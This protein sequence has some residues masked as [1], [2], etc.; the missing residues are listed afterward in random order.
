MKIAVIGGTGLLGSNLIKLF[1]NYDV[2]AFS[3][4][5]SV[6]IEENVNNL[7]DFSNI[8]I[9]LDTYFNSWCPDLIINTVALVDL[10]KCEDDL[11]LANFSN[12]EISI[13]L[14][15]LAKKNN[16]Y[17]IHVSTDHYYNDGKYRHNENENVSLLNNYAKTKY[18]AEEAVLDI[19]KKSLIVRTNIIGFRKNG[20]E[21]FFEW[22][23][24]NMSKE[25]NINLYENFFTSP[26][27]VNLLGGILLKCYK[28]GLVG[29]YNISSCES[30]SKYDFGMK[31]SKKFSF[32][33]KKIKKTVLIQNESSI[34]RA[35]TLGLNTSKIERDLDLKM[36]KIEEVIDSLY[37][38]YKKGD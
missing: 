18:K 23:I 27:S 13:N 5:H 14:A 29:I 8:T 16:S 11:P 7:I 6:N 24:N 2:R 19:Y 36:P 17:F 32:D 9:E 4:N 30:I 12:Y 1:K 37:Y 28:K 35:L 33:N 34:Q 21:S 31:V 25:L 26:I 38:E 3:R 15:E 10:Q 20:K 22:L